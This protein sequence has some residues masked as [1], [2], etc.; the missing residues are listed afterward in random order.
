MPGRGIPVGRYFGISVNLHYSWFIVFLLVTVLL[1]TAYFPQG[2]PD[3]STATYWG[4]GVVTSILFF[5]SV[6]AHELAHS[7]V[8][9]SAG[10]PVRVITLFIFGGVSRIEKEPDEPGVELRVA[11]AGPLT[12]LAISG[13]FWAIWAGV[14]GINEPVGAL[15]FWLGFINAVL[16][17]FNLIPGFPL[18]GGR[19]LRAVLWWRSRSLLNA[20]KTASNVG[21]GVGYLFIFAGIGLI[22]W[23][24]LLNGVWIAFIGWFLQNA[25]GASYRQMALQ[26]VLRGH[27]V[28]EVMTRD[29]PSISADMS[30]E[31]LINEYVLGKGRR[32]FPVVDDGRVLGLAT[33]NDLRKAPRESWH[34]RSVSEVMTPYD[35]LRWVGPGDELTSAL[36]TMTSEDVNQLPVMENGRIVG[37]VGRD[38]LLSFIQLR[39]A[40]GV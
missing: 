25:A 13:V 22:F 23:G 17:A 7:V 10:I 3:W 20:T 8:A 9:R 5:I 32:C 24:Y 21:R 26:S 34:S 31:Q 33:V 35:H 6:L 36:Q 19:V 27:K 14:A 40:L 30:L 12:S 38:S 28:S 11:L 39:S 4:I 29:C 37:M 1:A 18:D 15:A 2:Y 16:A